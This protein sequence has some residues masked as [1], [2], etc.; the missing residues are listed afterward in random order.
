MFEKDEFRVA[1][2]KRTTLYHLMGNCQCENFNRTARGT[3]IDLKHDWRSYVAPQVHAYNCTNRRPLA[4][5]PILFCF[6]VN[7]DLP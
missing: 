4:S 2:K 1:W 3:K 6:D 5:L 7:P